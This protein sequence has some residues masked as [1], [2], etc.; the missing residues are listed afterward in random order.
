M[1]GVMVIKNIG[2]NSHFFRAWLMDF[3]IGILTSL[4][5][6][7]FLPPLIQRLMAKLRI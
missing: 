2:L 5:F 1:T 6:S 7:F 4:P 3:G